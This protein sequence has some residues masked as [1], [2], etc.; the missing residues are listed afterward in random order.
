LRD[1]KEDKGSYREVTGKGRETETGTEGYGQRENLL[2]L[3]L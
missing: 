2:P 1:R 3:L